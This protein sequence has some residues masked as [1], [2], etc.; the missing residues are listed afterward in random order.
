MCLCNSQLPLLSVLSLTHECSHAD[1]L[2]T[3]LQTET[4]PSRD[5]ALWTHA[6]VCTEGKWVAPTALLPQVQALLASVYESV[7][8]LRCVL[9]AFLLFT[10]LCFVL[11]TRRFLGSDACARA[12]SA[13]R[14]FQQLQG[15]T[16]ADTAA[17]A[18]RVH[19]LRDA[20]GEP[21]DEDDT[22]HTEV[23]KKRVAIRGHEV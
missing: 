6:F 10:P 1:A 17:A 18:H 19:Q 21:L 5:L 8:K 23:R 20:V 11:L 16:H 3:L 9:L 12:S 2:E 13:A 4:L 7:G 22:P 14:L 15:E